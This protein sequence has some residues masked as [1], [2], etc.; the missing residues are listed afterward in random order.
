MFGSGARLGPIVRD[1]ALEFM[2]TLHNPIG[3]TMGLGRGIDIRF[4]VHAEQ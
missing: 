4:V 2:T 3:I 1:L